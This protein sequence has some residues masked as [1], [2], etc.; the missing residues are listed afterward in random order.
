MPKQS[1]R[2][3]GTSEEEAPQSEA[4]LVW[5]APHGEPPAIPSVPDHARQHR[6]TPAAALT[7]ALGTDAAIRSALP[8]TGLSG[9]QRARLRSLYVVTP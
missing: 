9:G 2:I 3:R 1:R 8:A 5:P 7:Q 6:D 4:R